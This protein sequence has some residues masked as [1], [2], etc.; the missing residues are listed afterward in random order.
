MTAMTKAE[1][2]A[3]FKETVAHIEKEIESL[4]SYFS[5]T[6]IDAWPFVVVL[7]QNGHLSALKALTENSFNMS[8]SG[9]DATQYSK[10]RATAIVKEFADKGYKVMGKYDFFKHQ[11]KHKKEMLVWFKEAVEKAESEI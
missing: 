4:E 2:L 6:C 8:A 10:E 5:V 7:D 9:R 3:S 11:L 1:A